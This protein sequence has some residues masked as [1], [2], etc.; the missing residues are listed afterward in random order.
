MRITRINHRP[1]RSEITKLRLA[2]VEGL[3][4]E[5]PAEDVMM[6]VMTD[7]ELREDCGDEASKGRRRE[8]E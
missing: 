7:Q 4:I 8:R 1:E 6:T 5:R 2:E 3:R